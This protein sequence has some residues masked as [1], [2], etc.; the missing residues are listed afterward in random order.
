MHA[1]DNNLGGFID[2]T[3]IY[4]VEINNCVHSIMTLIINYLILRQSGQITGAGIQR[5]KINTIS[6]LLKNQVIQI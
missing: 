2:F 4:T 5:I 3:T 6:W 1:F